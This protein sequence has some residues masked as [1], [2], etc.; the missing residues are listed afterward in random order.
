MQW[1][2]GNVVRLCPG[3]LLKACASE[4]MV[5]LC[6]GGLGPEEENPEETHS[7]DTYFQGCDRLKLASI[8]TVLSFKHVHVKHGCLYP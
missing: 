7:K 5:G 3:G 1:P 4:G 6:A 8:G 2:H